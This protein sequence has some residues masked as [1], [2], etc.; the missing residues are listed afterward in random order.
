LRIESSFEF[1]AR[2]KAPGMKIPLRNS[3]MPLRLL[4]VTAHPDDESGAFGGALMLAAAAGVETTIL[5]FTDGHAA[6]FHG[7]VAHGEDLG[8]VR[9]AEMAAACEIL[10][11]THHEILD[12]PDGQLAQQDFQQMA[13][14]VVEGIRRSRP[15]VVLTFGGDGGVNLHR[16]HT[17][18]SVVTTAAFHWAYR[19]DM[20]GEQLRAGLHPWT[21]QKLY[22]AS[23][24]FVS[25]RNHPELAGSP[26]GS[27]SLTLQLG[28][29]LG[30]RKIEAF[31]QH[32]TQQGV[33]QRVG[34]DRIRHM[35]V[36]R[37]LLAAT[38]GPIAVTDDSGMFS[39][40]KD[41]V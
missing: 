28:E 22:Y 29:N 39:G 14:V 27:W 40:L 10:G 16:D 3:G 7:E 37:Y 17:M 34:A 19:E 13:G 25:V 12:F 23:T 35:H 24:P 2:A 15:H 38:C 30:R 31:A 41:S 36:E 1:V 33:L 26:T 18:I 8:Q 4:C 5:C 9:R 21:A 11:V 20:F 6:H 32:R